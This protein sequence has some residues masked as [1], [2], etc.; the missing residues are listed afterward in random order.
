MRAANPSHGLASTLVDEFCRAGIEHACVSPGSRSAPLAMALHAEP[1]V[2]VH[3]VLDERSSA[4][5]AVGIAKATGIPALVVTTSGTAAANLHPAIVEANHAR[6]PLLAITAD[7]PPELRA[8]GAP[9]TID[10]T[11]LFGDSVRWYIDIGV[12]EERPDAAAYW[13]SVADRAVAAAIGPPAG[14]VHVNV[15]FRE[16]LVPEDTGWSF[17]LSG[18]GAGAPWAATGRASR[19]PGE[20]D[21]DELAGAV[22]RA[23]RGV[24]VCGASDGDAASALSFAERAGWPVL[25]EPASGLR[26]GPNAITTYDALLRCEAFAR[27][28]RPDLV[29]RVGA[30]GISRALEAWLGPG[31]PQVLIDPDGTWNDPGRAAARLVRADAGPLFE[32]LA[33]RIR[34]QP[35]LRWIDWW[36]GCEARARAAIDNILDA[37]QAASE[38]RTAR[39][40]AAMLP[41]GSALVEAASMPVRDLDWFMGARTGLRVVA[42]RG[43]N[44]IDGFVSTTLGVAR[45]WPGP[46]AALAGDLSMLHDQ[47]GLLAARAGDL[48]A[49]FVVINNNGGGVFSFLPQARWRDSFEKLFA[50]PQHVDFAALAG[51]HG[52]GHELVDHAANLC[53]ALERARKARGVNL[54]EVRTARDSNVA[55]H[56]RLWDAVA[57]AVS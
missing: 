10:Q 54:V 16:P 52:L 30:T 49:M 25:A 56:Q 21:L 39:D 48:D 6:T 12:A 26:S 17:D 15:P 29:L 46:V 57:R 27:S 33:G 28:H 9:Q 7:R 23:A 24:L 44:G 1:R 18:R 32:T 31:V 3:M 5:M 41:S 53:D 50:T 22:E 4:F 20:R 37:E 2:R 8:T 51:L 47:N 35:D 42:N 36:R 19:P 40:V 55:L 38:P 14:P 11:K 13:R 43:A 45:A 34:R